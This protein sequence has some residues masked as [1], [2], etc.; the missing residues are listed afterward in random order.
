MKNFEEPVMD[1]RFLYILLICLFF[2]LSGQARIYQV[3]LE[4]FSNNV[5]SASSEKLSRP[6]FIPDFRKT[7][8]LDEMV[9]P[10][11]INGDQIAFGY[12]LFKILPVSARQLDLGRIFENGNQFTQ[13]TTVAWN[14]PRDNSEKIYIASEARYV[15][16]VSKNEKFFD[17]NVDMLNIRKIQGTVKLQIDRLMF[18]E[19]HFIYDHDVFGL[20][21][22][23]EKRR[24]KLNELN[25]FDHPLFG[26]VTLVTPID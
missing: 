8:V 14:H 5:F 20:I 12:P 1:L 9:E 13:I 16:E 7:R 3:E 23:S 17:S 22:L 11:S 18:L 26:I 21:Q 10:I 24:I 2:P 6:T 25:Y 4:V 19:L 15:G